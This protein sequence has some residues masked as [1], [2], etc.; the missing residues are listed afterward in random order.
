MTNSPRLCVSPLRVLLLAV[1]LC[2]LGGRI[3]AVERKPNLVVFLSDDHGLLD[4]T[5]YGATDVR[6]PN[7][8]RLAAEGMTFTHAF[9]ASPACAPSRT[10]MLTGLMPARNGAEA[11][12]TFKREGLRSLPE[13]LIRLGYDVAAFGKVAHGNDVTRHGFTHHDNSYATHVVEEY[14]NTRDTTKPLC[15]F[16]GTR[17][18]HVPWAPNN[19]Y[20]PAKLHLPPTFVDTPET[21]EFRAR[22]YT[23]VTTADR[24]LGEILDLTRRKLGTDILFLYTSDHGAQWPFSKW[25]LYDAGIRSPLL[26]AWPGVIKPCSRAEAMVQWIDLLP[27][28]IDLAGGN[29]PADIDGRSFA[30]VL[31]GKQKTHRDAIFTTHSG[32]GRMNVYPIRALRTRDWKYI[33]NLHPEFAHTTHIDQAAGDGDGWRYFREWVWASQTNTGA[34]AVVKRYN[35]RPREEL[36]DLRADPYELRNLA[37]DPQHAARLAEMRAQLEAWMKEQ[38]DQRTVFQEPRLLSEPASYSP[39]TNP[40][41]A[42]KANE[43]K[44]QRKGKNPN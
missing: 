2:V 32:D 11:N 22:Y 16:V 10:A 25:N 19:G 39:V 21:R 30:D 35:E 43:A 42:T 7:M 26:A 28:L 24:E 8:Q 17:D 44:S 18:P 38:G 3:A 9:I 1:S 14:L 20:D 37:G 4:S 6:T 40:P 12:H 29:S 15:L 34:A 23:D 41:P 5:A 13:D 36:Y 33:L 27:T 31:R